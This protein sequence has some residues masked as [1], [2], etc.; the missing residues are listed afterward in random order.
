MPGYAGSNPMFFGVPFIINDNVKVGKKVTITDS[1]S[2]TQKYQ[3]Y[4]M[5]FLKPRAF[6]MLM[7]QTPKVEY[8]RNVLSRI[9]IITSTVWYAP[10][11]LNK[12][13]SDD[14]VRHATA[15]FLTYEQTT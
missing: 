2:A 7:K 11:H 6:G 15:E 3:S 13:I 10:L 8:A 12:R 14:D 9:D 1:A 5:H 4:Y